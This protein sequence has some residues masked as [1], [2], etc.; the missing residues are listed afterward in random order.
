[1]FSF[2][3]WNKCRSPRRMLWSLH[4]LRMVPITRSTNGIC[5]GEPGSVLAGKFQDGDE[6]CETGHRGIVLTQPLDVQV[7]P[8]YPGQTAAEGG[9]GVPRWVS[10]VDSRVVE[11]C[12]NVA[13]R[14]QVRSELVRDPLVDPLHALGEA[15]NLRKLALLD[16][17]GVKFDLTIRELNGSHGSIAWES[18]V[19]SGLGDR[20]RALV[21]QS[22][23]R[24]PMQELVAAPHLQL[25]NV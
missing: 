25:Q 5:Q 2:K 19:R 21:E 3:T 11:R 7:G 17:R 14:R 9:S 18:Q 15:V 20:V 22:V 4:F 6:S 12:T 10:E 8:L 23:D 1:M 24:A 13:P 16:R